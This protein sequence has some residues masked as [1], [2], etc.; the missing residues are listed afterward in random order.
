MS[1]K[2]TALWKIP[3]E[4]FKNG[5]F[6]MITVKDG[7]KHEK[8][9]AALRLLTD[10][11]TTELCYGGAAGGAKTWTG[12]CWLLFMCL[13]YPGTRWFVGRMELKELEESVLVTFLEVA[14]AY[15]VIKDVDFRYRGDKHWIIFANGSEIILLTF[16]ATPGDPNFDGLGSTEYTGGWMEEAPQ[17]LRRVYEVLSTRI[18][19][20]FNDKYNIVGKLLVTCNPNKQWIYHTF[21]LPS[22]NGVLREGQYFLQVLGNENPHNQSGYQKKLDQLTGVDR[23]RLRDG[24]WDYVEDDRMLCTNSEIDACFPSVV[25]VS[26]TTKGYISGDIAMQGR[27]SCVFGYWREYVIEIVLDELLSDPQGIEITLRGIMN[28]KGVPAGNV[29]TDSA[30]LG[31]YLSGYVKGIVKFYSQGKAKNHLE[32][33]DIRSEC[34]YKLAEAI[35]KGLLKIICSPEQ[36]I[37][38]IQE[39]GYLMAVSVDNDK[40][41][42]L[43][44]KTEIKKKLLRSPDYLDMLIMGMWFKVG[45]KNFWMIG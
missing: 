13:L 35:K 23:Q 34:G 9:E 12:C 14:A 32:F 20:K 2:L 33:A 42:Q 19:R 21:Y 38:I 3:A 36:K 1:S 24:D 30:G 45:N 22:R 25:E 15:E 26:A 10:N 31:E 29:V 7:K 6:D 17:A 41:K 8:Q 44:A 39:L 40:R 16:K 5:N 43:L 18:G 11:V 27:D 37:K 4:R 28:N